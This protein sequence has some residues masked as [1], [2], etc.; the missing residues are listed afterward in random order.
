MD[1]TWVHH[2]MPETKQQ[3]KK[4]VEANGSAPNKAKSIISAGKVMA[5][6]HLF[7]LLKK[8]ASEKHFT[9]KEV[10]RAEYLTTFQTLI[11]GME[12]RY[13]R[14]AGPML[15]SGALKQSLHPSS[16]KA[17]VNFLAEVAPLKFD[18]WDQLFLADI[19]RDQI[20]TVFLC[21]P[22]GRALGWKGLPCEIFKVLNS[23]GLAF[24]FKAQP[25]YSTAKAF[26]PI[27]PPTTNYKVLNGLLMGHLHRH[28]SCLV[29]MSD[30]RRLE[31]ISGCG[32]VV[33]YADDI[34]LFIRDDAQFE[35]VPLIFEKF[36]MSSGV[37]VNFSKSCG[38]WCGCWKH[39][40]DTPLGIFWTSELLT[41]LGCTITARNIF[42]SHLWG[43]WRK[44]V[45]LHSRAVAGGSCPRGQQPGPGFY[46]A[47]HPP[48]AGFR[49]G[50]R[51]SGGIR[52]ESRGFPVAS[53]LA[54]TPRMA[55]ARLTS[56]ANFGSPA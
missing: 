35:L 50:S 28:L 19:S 38:I 55:S 27:S 16:A 30:Q 41:V 4:R 10:E 12:Y 31:R 44:V 17:I 20:T 21:L 47:R 46:P 33:A 52:A 23:A 34:V 11:P 14:N 36:R 43:C 1:E 49:R 7:P 29:P 24:I 6:F 18:E 5:N 26:R 9:S 15:P 54:Q 51:A 53:W 8:F 22:N 2:Y 39:R 25:S 45:S 13:W 56:W 32:C 48:S 40:T 37:A 42:A 3:S